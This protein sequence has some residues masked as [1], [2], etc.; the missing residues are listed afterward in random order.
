MTPR[1]LTPWGLVVI[2]GLAIVS[3]SLAVDSVVQFDPQGWL[4]WGREVTSPVLHFSTRLYPSWK[5][6]PFLFAVPLSLTGGAAPTLWLAIE[7][8]AALTGLVLAYSLARGVAGRVAGV[9]AAAGL[10]LT[11]GWITFAIDGR[12]E[13]IVIALLLGGLAA[14]RADRRR[15]ALVLF[16]LASLDRPE[17]LAVACV[18]A[19]LCTP[20]NLRD[21]ALAAVLIAAVPVMWLGGDWLGSGD[22]FHG[23]QLAQQ[24]AGGLRT[25]PEPPVVY[26]VRTWADAARLPLIVGAL[27]ATALAIKRRERLVLVLAAATFVW[28]AADASLLV[29]GYPASEIP[30]YVLPAAALAC[31]LGGI[32]LGRLLRAAPRGRLQLAAAVALA[33]LVAPFAWQGGQSAAAGVRDA[34]SYARAIGALNRVIAAAG[35]SRA[36]QGCGHLAVD[37]WAATGLAWNLDMMP[38]GV[39]RPRVPGLI[40]ARLGV[41]YPA[42]SRLESAAEI[43]RLGQVDRWNILY[44]GRPAAGCAVVTMGHPRDYDP[45]NLHHS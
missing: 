45:P 34:A 36:F 16:V 2:A 35:G 25:P 44:A 22:P 43:W 10:A 28:L 41:R 26:L 7:R 38:N 20:R 29:R 21:F 17:A 30:R 32:G 24:S 13:P 6:L 33:A 18:Y 3:V 23:A 27:V 37:Q 31:V 4:L 1:K 9:A 42:L 19:L 5:P 14:H 11:P 40:L 8:T 39:A 12:S 15:L